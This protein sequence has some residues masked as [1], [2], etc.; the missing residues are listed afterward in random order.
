MR[1]DKNNLTFPFTIHFREAY[2]A[3]VAVRDLNQKVDNYTVIHKGNKIIIVGILFAAISSGK[4][5]YECVVIISQ[6]PIPKKNKKVVVKPRFIGIFSDRNRG[7]P[8]NFQALIQFPGEIDNKPKIKYELNISPLNPRRMTYI[9]IKERKQNRRRKRR[10]RYFANENRIKFYDVIQNVF[11]SIKREARGKIVSYIINQQ[12]L[13]NDVS[14]L[15]RIVHRLFLNL[16]L[17][18]NLLGKFTKRMFDMMRY[19]DFLLPNQFPERLTSKLEIMEE[20]FDK[21]E[22]TIY[23]RKDLLGFNKRPNIILEAALNGMRYSGAQILTIARYNGELAG[24]Y[25]NGYIKVPLK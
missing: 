22:G 11:C 2:F 12:D 8:E 9:P 25:Y 17:S 24:S 6:E 21:N 14:V 1:V 20:L 18:A 3:K 10:N 16:F 4:K 7:K 19:E 13:F 15:R 23:L 5:T